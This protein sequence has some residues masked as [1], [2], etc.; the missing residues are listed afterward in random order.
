[1]KKGSIE[2][3]QVK[4]FTEDFINWALIH[5]I[6]SF[7]FIVEHYSKKA[8]RLVLDIML[9]QLISEFMNQKY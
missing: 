4:E 3:M 7:E 5:Q 6:D 2:A 8:M 1:M 9:K